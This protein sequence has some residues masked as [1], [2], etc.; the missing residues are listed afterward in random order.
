MS[1][2][3]DAPSP[4]LRVPQNVLL[5]DIL[6][7]LLLVLMNFAQYVLLVCAV[8]QFLWMAVARERNGYIAEFGVQ[9]A[10]WVAI[11]ARFVSGASDQKPFPWTA[12]H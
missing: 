11:S 1:N 12:W 2:I 9:I 4:T 7:L 6:M 3:A 8:L 5:H 10:N